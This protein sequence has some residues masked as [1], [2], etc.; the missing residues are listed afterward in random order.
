M[1]KNNLFLVCLLVI[2]FILS[3]CSGQS[4]K[5]AEQV[6]KI[7]ATSVPH[8]EILNVIKPNLK[9]QGIDLKIIEMDDYV[10]PNMALADKEVD[11]NFFQHTP[12]LDKFKT[13]RNLKI[14]SAGAIHIEP[15]GLYSKKIRALNDLPQNAQI[16]IPNDPTNGGRALNLLQKAGLIKLKDGVGIN[17]TV[18]DII[19]NPKKIVIKELEAP[20][21]PRVLDDVAAAVINT[22]YALQANL[23][24]TK[25]ALVIESND[26]PYANIV[27][28]RE[29]EVN[30]PEIQKLMQALK[31]DEV[32]KFINEKYKGAIVPTF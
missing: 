23:V 16:A 18:K 5:A 26:S 8:A 20:Q 1:K 10:R 14:V 6:L 15:M 9:N 12:Y 25:D 13:E 29:G 4:P 3:G 22:N 27:A 7:A 19:D 28:V 24:P 32:K 17:A 11:A 31:S 21:L 30:R 2:T